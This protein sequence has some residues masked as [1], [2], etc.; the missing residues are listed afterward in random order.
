ENGFYYD[1]DLGGKNL[2]PEE[3]DKIEKKMVELAKLKNQYVRKDVSKADA[4]AYFTE[5]GDEYKIE[6]LQDLPDGEITFYQQGNFT[7]LCRGPHLPDTG[8]IKAIK[9]LS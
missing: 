4:I 7:D 6:L 8:H 9:L 3:L 2:T 5:K 1:I